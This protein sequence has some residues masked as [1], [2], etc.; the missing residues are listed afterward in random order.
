MH[1][2]LDQVHIEQGLT[3]S[4]LNLE[5]TESLNHYVQGPPGYLPLH[6]FRSLPAIG[7][8]VTTA[9]VAVSGNP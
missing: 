3:T 6:V 4:E 5:A 1:H 7:V 8:T 2:L 9:Q